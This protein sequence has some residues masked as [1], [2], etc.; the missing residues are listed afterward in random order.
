M[1]EDLIY[2]WMITE[3]VSEMD[4]ISIIV[5]DIFSFIIRGYYLKGVGG[6]VKYDVVA[7]ETCM[8]IICCGLESKVFS[9]RPSIA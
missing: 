8:C 5:L 2:I 9:L 4:P 7:Y 3:N 1:E 6:V